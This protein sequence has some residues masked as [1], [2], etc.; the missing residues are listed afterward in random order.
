MQQLKKSI[1]KMVDNIV[2][3][4]NGQIKSIYLY[5]SCVLNDFKLGW[6]DID[7][8]V[9]TKD[10]LTED[11]SNKLLT[12]RQQLLEKD[13]QN[14][15]YRS[16]E[17]AILSFDSFVYNKRDKVVYWGTKGEKIKD[18]YSLDSFSTKELLEN[19]ELLY[20]EDVRRFFTVP[21]FEDLKNDI[22]YHYGT[23]REHARTT[24]RNFYSFGW[25][26]DISRCLYTLQTG[27][28]IAKTL[29]GEWALEH[30]LCPNPEVLE[31]V[32]EI[33]KNAL[34]Y[35]QKPE[36]FDYA[37]TLG[38]TVQKYADVLERALTSGHNTI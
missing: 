13:P 19:G 32:L 6:S 21:T 9:L 2:D 22:R 12:L 30:K 4:L 23:I 10:S 26:L 15:Y 1:Q 27:K 24:G 38:P 16:F 29:A 3:I 28:I 31:K 20:G 5:G 36:T 14:L 35:K 11:A 37:E 34:E 17:G 8:L 18:T 7:I 33:R 25:F